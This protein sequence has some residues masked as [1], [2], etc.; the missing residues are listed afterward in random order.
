MPTM[1]VYFAIPGTPLVEL[2]C[3]IILQTKSWNALDVHGF[4]ISMGLSTRED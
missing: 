3:R 1:T 4:F 2:H